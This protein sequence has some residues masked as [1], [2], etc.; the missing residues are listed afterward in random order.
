M[1]IRSSIWG[2]SGPK[3]MPSF[4]M[5]TAFALLLI[6]CSEQLHPADLPHDRAAHGAPRA[7]VYTHGSRTSKKVALTIDDCWIDDE[8][9]FDLLAEYGIVCTMFIPGIVIDRRSEW[10]AEYSRKGFEICNHTYHHVV[11][12]TVSIEKARTEILQAEA[13]IRRVTGTRHPYFRP[14][15]GQYSPQLLA[16]LGE[17]GYTVIMWE[18]DVLGYWP[19]D[20]I[21]TQFDYIRTHKRSGNIILVHPGES[22]RGCEVL[23]VIIPEMLDEG[24]EFVTVSE[25]LADMEKEETERVREEALRVFI[26]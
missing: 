4:L 26:P 3:I 8:P 1:Q 19:E 21:S 25:L 9:L 22:L 14:P 15:K 17:L 20:P 7:A 11:L 24:Y 2:S 12:T 5:R 16:L 13:A 10:A 23:K 18:N 6:L